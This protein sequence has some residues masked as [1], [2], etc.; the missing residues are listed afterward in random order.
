MDSLQSSGCSVKSNQ[1]WP[2][3]M[4]GELNLDGFG[5]SSSLPLLSEELLGAAHPG[6]QLIQGM[7]E[8]AQSQKASLQFMLG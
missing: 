8:L 1:M 4:L 2:Y 5:V 7:L 6:Q 3:V